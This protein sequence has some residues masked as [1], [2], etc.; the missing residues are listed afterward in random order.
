MKK[1][2]LA[3]AVAAAIVSMT[4][5]RAHTQ[6]TAFTY[7]M[8]A[9]FPGD[10]NRTHPASIPP[11]LIHQSTPPLLYGNGVL[12]DTAS[13]S[14]RGVLA[15]D[16]SDSVAINLDGI[17]VRPYPAQQTT[18]G[19]TSTFG[20]AVPP[21]GQPLDVCEDGYVIVKCNVG[22]PTKKGAVYIWCSASTGSH[23]Q[24]GFESAADAGD[25]VLVKNAYFNGPPDASGITEI[26]IWNQNAIS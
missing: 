23:V 21:L 18:G 3:L 12:I 26:R 11:G 4:R 6:D 7:R 2:I 20:T 19:M 5:T 10:V 24:G 15:G 9:G 22:T 16:Q 13:N 14:Y 17:A 1:Q 8:G 25:T